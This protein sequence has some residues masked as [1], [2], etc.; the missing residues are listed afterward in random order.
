MYVGMILSPSS[1]PSFSSF[2]LSHSPS[3]LPF[4]PSLPFINHPLPP[5]HLSRLL[6]PLSTPL[7]FLDSSPLPLLL[8]PSLTP[9]PSLYSSPSSPSLLPLLLSLLPL[10]LS[11]LLHSSL[12]LLLLSSPGLTR[13][14]N[15]F[16]SFDFSLLEC[17]WI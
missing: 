6:P 7:P 13:G 1:F 4:L 11:H 3:L 16:F 9:P 2:T 17:D 14:G 5:H 10:L 12:V 8:S 15:A